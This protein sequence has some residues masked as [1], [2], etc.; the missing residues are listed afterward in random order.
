M[1]VVICWTNYSGYM[2]ACWRELASQPGIDLHVICFA[3]AGVVRDSA[4]VPAI[5]AGVS[6]DLLDDS[7][8]RDG[9]HIHQ[10]VFAQRPDVVVLPGWLHPGYNRLVSVGGRHGCRFV[11]AMD[12]P[13]RGELRQRLA[14]LWLGRLLHKI[15]RVIVAGERARNYALRLGFSPDR[16]HIGV[17]GFD[18]LLFNERILC[19]REQRPGGWPRRFLFVGRYVPDKAVDVLVAA[20]EHYR[21][22]VRDPW[23]L[24][25]CGKGPLDRLLHETSGV[26]D[27]GFVQPCDQP[28]L[29]AEHGVFVLPSR[30]E[31]WGV[32]LAEAMASGMPVICSSACNAGVSL[33]H[34][35]WNG[36]EV[37]PSDPV[38]LARA[39][40]WM[41]EHHRGLPEMGR[42]AATIAKAYSA[43]QWAMRWREVCTAACET[44]AGHAARP[45]S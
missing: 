30:Y 26:H 17:Y 7:A 5:P 31:P 43:S 11:M 19:E 12:T 13:F 15:D 33:L 35:L 3:P 36:L 27:Y 40:R 37:P 32:A 25:G 4:F 9:A 10:I 22:L 45:T 38:A 6:V 8:R 20:Y 2:A 21:S 39:M 28:A 29:F 14:P 16:I 18:H 42:A 24:G 34:P 23:P 41:H 1:K 44:S